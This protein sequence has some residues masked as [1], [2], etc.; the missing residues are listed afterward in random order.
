MPSGPGVIDEET[1]AEIAASVPEGIETFLLT[2]KSNAE[3]IIAQHRKCGT[4]AIQIVDAIPVKD[5]S[6]LRNNLPGIKLVQVIHVRSKNEID[7]ALRVQRYVDYILLDSGNPELK[8]KELGGTGRTHNWEISRKILEKVRIPVFLAGGLK[9]SNVINAVKAV[10]PYGLDVCSG[11]R[12]G[13]KLDA[14]KLKEFIRKA[15]NSHQL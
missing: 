13:G 3:G 15:N 1:I 5:Y 10:S 7:E 11:V 8:T 12:T 9:P 4:S 14:F 2:S 6:T